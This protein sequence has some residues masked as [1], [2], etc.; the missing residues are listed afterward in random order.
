MRLSA[1]GPFVSSALRS[2]FF[3]FYVSYLNMVHWA[4]ITILSL[5]LNKCFWCSKSDIRCV[6]QAVL[7]VTT[8]ERYNL[9]HWIES[10][11]A[12]DKYVIIGT[13]NSY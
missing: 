10:V 12:V 11:V 1:Y 4:C 6:Q 9:E 3:C 8:Q 2:R 7:L 13:D 5:S